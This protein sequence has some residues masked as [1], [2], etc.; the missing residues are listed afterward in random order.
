MPDGEIWEVLTYSGDPWSNPSEFDLDISLEI[1]T[2]GSLLT[3]SAFS[4]VIVPS[5]K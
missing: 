1:L 2:G 4:K 5:A 3:I